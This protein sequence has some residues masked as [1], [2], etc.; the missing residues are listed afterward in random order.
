MATENKT[1]DV[2]SFAYTAK[3]ENNET[4][5]LTESVT[6]AS[7][8][9]FDNMTLGDFLKKYD[10]TN[11]LK[12]AYTNFFTTCEALPVETLTT[13][14]LAVLLAK[15]YTSVQTSKFGTAQ[16]LGNVFFLG[17][18]IA[19]VEKF[20]AGLLESVEKALEEARKKAEAEA[21]AEKTALQLLNELAAVPVATRSA[22]IKLQPEAVQTACARLLAADLAKNTEA[23]AKKPKAK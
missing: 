8:A 3:N 2:F 19:N 9:N 5:Q 7:R 6:A 4:I 11:T 10:P 23:E 14:I 18:A 16:N 1:T 22:I 15:N 17:G 21:A 20:G 12:T 13:N